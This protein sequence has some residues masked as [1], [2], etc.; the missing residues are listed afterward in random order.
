[1]PDFRNWFI[2]AKK[3]YHDKFESSS[4]NAINKLQLFVFTFIL[5]INMLL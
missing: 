1:M 3:K 5:I 2:M 4:N